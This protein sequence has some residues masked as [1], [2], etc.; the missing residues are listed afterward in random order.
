METSNFNECVIGLSVGGDNYHPAMPLPNARQLNE[1][2][3]HN[4]NYAEWQ[5]LRISAESL[6]IADDIVSVYDEDTGITC[7]YRFVPEC[8]R[9]QFEAAIRNTDSI[10]TG[11]YPHYTLERN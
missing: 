8:H 10:I 11:S 6:A 9:E 2:Y 7:W 1:G 3:C 4:G 5:E